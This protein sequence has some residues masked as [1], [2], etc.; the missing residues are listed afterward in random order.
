[1]KRSLLFLPFILFSVILIAVAANCQDEA[2]FT[3]FNMFGDVQITID[4]PP[5]FSSLKKNE[6]IF[7]ALPNGNS[8]AQTMEKNGAG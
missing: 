1:M 4:I 3:V 7:Y 2:S 5:G 6:I 8:T